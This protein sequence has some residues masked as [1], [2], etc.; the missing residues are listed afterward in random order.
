M[1]R[2]VQGRLGEKITVSDMASVAALSRFHFARSFRITFGE[3]PMKYVS[4]MRVYAAIR[5]IATGLPLA[6]VSV[7]CGFSSQSHMNQSFARKVGRTP[8]SFRPV[9]TP[10][11]ISS[12]CVRHNP[13]FSFRVELLPGERLSSKPCWMDEC[14]SYLKGSSA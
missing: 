5:F 3:P 13:C 1:A 11:M 10:Y 9:V 2:F 4:R 12:T 7:L 6:Q 14:E 8:G